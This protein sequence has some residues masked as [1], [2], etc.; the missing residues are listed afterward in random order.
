MFQHLFEPL[1]LGKTRV[2]NRICFN[3]HRTNFAQDGGITGQLAAYYRRRAEGGCGLIIQGEFS[4]HPNDRP[5]AAMIHLYQ[6]NIADSLKPFAASIH[7]AGARVFANLNHHG[8]QSGSAITRHVCIGPSA[9]CD[10]EFGETAKPAEPEDLADIKKAF[11]RGA[12]KIR[13]SGYDGIQIDMGPRS[14]LRQFLSALSNHRSDEYGGSLENRMRFP[15][16]V[17]HAV[18]KAVGEDFTVGARL[19]ADE[20]F[21]GAITMDESQTMAARLETAGHMDF[22]NVAVG[23][24]YNLHL[25]SASMHMPAGF[26]QE[27][28]AGIKQAVSIPVIGG[29]QIHSAGMA[30]QLIKEH[31]MDMAGLIRNLICDPDLPLKAR[32]NDMSSIRSCVWDNNGCMGR[33]R[34]AKKLGCIQNPDVG[35]EHLPP[36]GEKAPCPK[37]VWVAGA[38]PA[39]L[40]AARSATL[41]GHDVTVFEQE[42]V[43]GGQINLQRMGAG[44]RSMGAVIRHLSDALVQLKVPIHTGKRLTTALVT[45]QRPDAVIIATGSKPVPRPLPGDYGPPFVLSVPDVLT[46]SPVGEKVLFVDENGGH[47]AAASVEFLADMGKQVD[48]ITSDLFIGIELTGT[49]DLYL[50]RQRLLTKGVAFL[51]DIRAEEI[52]DRTLL[53]RHIYSNEVQAFTGYDTIVLDMGN[54]PEDGLYFELKGKVQELY[55]IGDCVAP[56]GV[57]MAILEGRK[58]GEIL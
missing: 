27:I 36:G 23:T 18:R 35:Y 45:A 39:G 13:E 51:T 22:I 31:K 19:C 21:Y 43:L 12:A 17:A 50:S 2:S 37:K 40:E 1:G 9:I 49:G 3:P 4:I 53:G 25:Q 54:I 57:D 56:R 24:Y 20:M 30:E 16:E 10:I 41:R 32:R 14:L 55:R 11:A 5:W 48:M 58:A 34:Q 7:T 33:T 42:D 28:T 46:G 15:L 44:R 38:G 26:S 6:D 52:R 8:F 47:H 29:Y